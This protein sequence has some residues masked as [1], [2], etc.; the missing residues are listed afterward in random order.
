MHLISDI[1]CVVFDFDG[2]IVDSNG[3]KRDAFLAVAEAFP[4]GA[5]LMAEILARPDAGDRYRVMDSFHHAL[6]AAGGVPGAGDVPGG[7]D[8]ANRYT[9][10]VE[11]LVLK[12][13]EIPGA[14]D[15]LRWLDDAGIPAYL[16]SATPSGPLTRIIAQSRFA[17]LFK[18]IYG[19]PASKAENLR[20]IMDLEGVGPDQLL[21]VGDGEPDRV[22]AELIGC[23]FLA[24]ENSFSRF[25][26]R[27][28]AIIADLTGFPA[29]L[30]PHLTQKRG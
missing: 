9:A 25:A 19:G 4:G 2:T 28:S 14:S 7:L 24:L 26:Q 12:A 8:L 16:N 20:I 11:E 10:M 29:I 18:G 6:R 13:A 15:C 22:G 27:P 17:P 5:V 23:P 21:M 3:I 30:R 1:R